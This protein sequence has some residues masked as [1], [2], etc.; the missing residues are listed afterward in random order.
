MLSLSQ[1]LLLFRSV[2]GFHNHLSNHIKQNEFASAKFDS[3]LSRVDWQMDWWSGPIHEAYL[4]IWKMYTSDMTELLSLLSGGITP[5]TVYNMVMDRIKEILHRAVYT[6]GNLAK[7]VSE[8]ELPNVLSHVTG[9]LFHDAFL[10]IKISVLDI[11]SRIL[12][13][14]I[15]ELVVKPCEELIAPLQETIDAIPIPG[16]SVLIDLNSLLHE[17]VD[18]ITEGALLSIINSAVSDVKTA[19]GVASAEIGIASVS[20]D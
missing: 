8:G 11:L 5:Y 19:L 17:T 9:L 3:T 15:N 7:S 10:M 2:Q 14:P 13:G 6:F 12:N 18:E 4:V 20:L 16:L 1:L